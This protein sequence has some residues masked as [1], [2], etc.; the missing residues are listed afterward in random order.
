MKNKESPN[1]GK[2]FDDSKNAVGQQS[3]ENRLDLFKDFT[4]HDYF[5]DEI[6]VFLKEELF[7]YNK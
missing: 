5:D 2:F 6:R 3:L 1:G 4:E 7:S